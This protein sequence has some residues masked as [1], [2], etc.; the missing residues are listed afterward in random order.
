MD[1][2][3]KVNLLE[4]IRVVYKE[5]ILI[6]SIV[7][8]FML[9]GIAYAFLGRKEFL[10]SGRILPELQT[11]MGGNLSQFA[12]LA[13]LAGVDLSSMGA[14]GMDAVRPDLYP[15]VL[16]STPFF[17]KLMELPILTVDNDSMRFEQYY[18]LVLEDSKE[19]TEKQL[20]R[21]PVKAEGI[22]LINRLEETRIKSLRRRISSG[23]D[24]KSGIITIS[25]KMPDPVVAAK[26]A[27]FAMSYL[28]EY[29]KEYRTE[30]LKQDVSYLQDQ[31]EAAKGNYYTNQVKKARYTD[32]FQEMRLQTADVQR[33]RIDAE[34]RLSSSFYNELL[35][36]YEEAKFKL[37]QETPIFKVLEPPVV[38]NKKSEPKGIVVIFFSSFIGV[39][40]A[41]FIAFLRKSNYKMVV[42]F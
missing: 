18:H 30:K 1:K 15:D 36:K 22:I 9:F 26:I 11:K 42:S 19:P 41:T 23:I 33:E 16:S 40:M 32:Q 6:F 25:V 24:K 12:G 14:G 13:S 34:Y 5:R 39:I 38:P 2:D 3:L 29:V 27:S 8:V 17:I 21:F 20:K 28:M 37:H 4:A 10:S 7:F 35:K 31:L